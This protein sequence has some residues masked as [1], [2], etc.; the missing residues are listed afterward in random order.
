MLFTQPSSFSQTSGFSN[1]LRDLQL[2][3]TIHVWGTQEETEEQIHP[4]I[5]LR[6]PETLES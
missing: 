3:R 5:D 6:E 1:H 2:Q 4:D